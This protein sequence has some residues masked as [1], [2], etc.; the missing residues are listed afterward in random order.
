MS[1]PD[2]LDVVEDAILR[3][4][5]PVVT[6]PELAE[7][8]LEESGVLDDVGDPRR[9]VLSDLSILERD[10]VVESKRTGA[11]ARAW[12]HTERVVAPPRDDVDQRDRESQLDAIESDPDLEEVLDGWDPGRSPEERRERLDAG[13]AVLEWL[14]DRGEPVSRA[15]VIRSTHDEL[16]PTGQSED[17]Y[18]R[19]TAREAFQRAAEKGLVEIDGRRY[20]WSG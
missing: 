10:G 17:S 11:H 6:A 3:A 5:P 20:L 13:L 12:W 16:A 9:E 18:W 1:P 8:V 7:I 4:D 14:R 19:K 2:R 15:D